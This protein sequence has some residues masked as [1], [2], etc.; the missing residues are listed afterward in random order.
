MEEPI[1]VALPQPEIQSANGPQCRKP[2][3][4]AVIRASNKS[5]VC[6]DHW[7]WANYGDGRLGKSLLPKPKATKKSKSKSKTAAFTP[8]P[9]AASE[10]SGIAMLPVPYEALDRFW[11]ALP[12]E[13]KALIVAKCISGVGL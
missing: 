10:P 9:K 11:N 12:W 7:Y 2:G 5:G 1:E 13:E 4:T 8:A 3:C 6:A